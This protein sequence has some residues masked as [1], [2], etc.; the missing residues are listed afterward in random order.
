MGN[1]NLSII[2]TVSN[3]LNF[4]GIRYYMS[5]ITKNKLIDMIDIYSILF[6]LLNKYY[7]SILPKYSYIFLMTKFKSYLKM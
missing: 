7:I 1:D 5:I 6:N 4:K 2:P 3:L